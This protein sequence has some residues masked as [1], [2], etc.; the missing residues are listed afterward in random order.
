MT[1]GPGSYEWEPAA[2]QLPPPR[3]LLIF[4]EGFNRSADCASA[5]CSLDTLALPHFDNVARA[6][7]TFC[8]AMRA[9]VHKPVPVLAMHLVP[10]CMIAMLMC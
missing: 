3:S 2:K 1:I 7:V 4:L 5:C 10:Q 6:G 8:A 9:G